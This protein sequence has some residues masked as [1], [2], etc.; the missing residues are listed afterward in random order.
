MVRDRPLPHN[1]EVEKGFLGSV[2]AKNDLA[3]EFMETLKPE[4]FFEPANGELWK[5]MLDQITQNR[6]VSRQTLLADRAQDSDIG[7]ITAS[8]YIESLVEN[9]VDPWTARDYA[10]VIRDLAMKRAVIEVGQRMIEAGFNAPPSMTGDE[11]RAEMDDEFTALY[12]GPIDL[13]IQQIAEIGN[14]VI[15]RVES[16]VQGRTPPGLGSGLKA[17]TDLIGPLHPGD[18]IAIGGAPGSGKTALVQQVLEDISADGSKKCLLYSIEMRRDRLAGRMLAAAAGIPVRDIR[19]GAGIDRAGQERLVEENAKRRVSGLY[20]ASPPRGAPT[21]MTIRATGLRMQRTVGL[22][23]MG[24]DHLQYIGQP[25]RGMEEFESVDKNLMMLKL[26]GEDLGI[27]VFILV[28]MTTGA[29]RDMHKWP[30]RK[31]NIGDLLF[32]GVVERH[33]DAIVLIHQPLYFLKRNQPEEGDRTLEEWRQRVAKWQG[34]GPNTFLILGK[35]RDGEGYGERMVY[36]DG[37]RVRFTDGAP[38]VTLAPDID[39]LL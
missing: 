4:E 23:A 36:F 1:L 24:V 26:M 18:L 32:S 17:L 22:D 31:A 30:H 37:K 25:E 8:G 15:D 7:G 16:A 28:Q 13:G 6:Q 21:A 34:Y 14:T 19:Q 3:F 2:I 38:P 10:R 39:R 9:A 35:S 27:P 11:L 5:L 12:R 29:L 33:C 20:I